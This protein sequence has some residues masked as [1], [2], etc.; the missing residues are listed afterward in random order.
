MKTMIVAG[1]L[2]SASIGIA[3]AASAA[4]APDISTLNPAVLKYMLPDKI[5]WEVTPGLDTAYLYGH[6]SKPG[7]YVLMY[8]WKPGNSSHPHYHSK[9]RSIMVLS[10]TWWVGAGTNWDPEHATAPV[11]PGTYVTHFARQVHYDGARMNDEPAVEL[12]WGEGPVATVVCD[13]ANAEKGPGP[14]EDA[15]KSA[16]L[17]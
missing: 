9:D 7:F 15:R 16:G 10:G 17:N 14:C 1:V 12:V 6:P 2:L 5:P 3:Y 13:G 4:S 11:K 8:R